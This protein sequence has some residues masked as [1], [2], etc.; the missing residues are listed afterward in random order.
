M[1]ELARSETITL[2]V[3]DDDKQVRAFCRKCLVRAGFRVLEADNGLEALLLASNHDGLIDLLITDVELP[4]IRGPELVEAF[5]TLWPRTRVLFISGSCSKSVRGDL[6]ADAA[7][8]RKPFPPDELVKTV[9][10]LA[11]ANKAWKRG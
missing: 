9:R 5:R 1:Q 10:S 8:L 6:G 7:F 4:H 11:A 2:L 3:I